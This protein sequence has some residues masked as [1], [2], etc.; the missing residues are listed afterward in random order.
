MSVTDYKRLTDEFLQMA[1]LP[2]S[3]VQKWKG[4]LVPNTFAFGWT[5]GFVIAAAKTEGH[6]RRVGKIVERLTE[7]AQRDEERKKQVREPLQ[8][9]FYRGEM[10]GLIIAKNL[11]ADAL[12]IHTKTEP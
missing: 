1:H 11:L 7:L 9:E 6:E 8:E 4:E 12:G 5:A 10:C 2:T 3:D